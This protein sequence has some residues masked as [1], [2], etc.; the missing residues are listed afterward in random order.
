MTEMDWMLAP[1]DTWSERVLRLRLFIDEE[2]REVEKR[3]GIVSDD[4]RGNRT[5]QETTLVGQMAMLEG[6]L[7]LA[8]NQLRAK[9]DT[10]LGERTRRL[11]EGRGMG[12]PLASREYAE[13]QRRIAAKAGDA[14]LT[15]Y[16]QGTRDAWDVVMGRKEPPEL[17]VKEKSDG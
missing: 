5:R 11:A 17:G 2:L 6:A 12:N 1:E 14:A 13:E 3:H 7:R 16:W 15:C 8:A 4:L 9:A 10:L